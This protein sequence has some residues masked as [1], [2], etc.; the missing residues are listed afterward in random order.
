MN[1]L[2]G[3]KGNLPARQN[4][5]DAGYDLAAGH[6]LILNPGQ[7]KAVF[8]GLQLEMPVGMFAMV[9][10]RSGLAAKHSVFVLNAPGIIDSGFRGPIGVILHNAGERAF[11]IEAGDRIAQLVFMRQ[12]AVDLQSVLDL[13]ESDRGE[14]GFGSTGM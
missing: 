13:S 11:M 14:G 8:T 4:A 2:V 12:T 1:E 7:T 10:S 3:Y 5:D 9:C 6:P